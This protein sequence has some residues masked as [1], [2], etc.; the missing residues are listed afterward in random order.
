M[1]G[2]AG[3]VALEERGAAI[4]AAVE[5]GLVGLGGI[6]HRNLCDVRRAVAGGERLGD[7][8]FLNELALRSDAELVHVVAAEHVRAVAVLATGVRV[9]LRV[10]HQQHHVRLVLQ[11]DLG[12]ILETDVAH[13][14]VAADGPHLGQLAHFLVGHQRVVEA[15]EGK[16]LGLAGHVAFAREQR[17]GQSL[18]R[19]GTARVIDNRRLADE[20]TDG[21][22]VLKQRVHPRIRMRI[23]RRRGAVNGVAAG[24]RAHVHDAHAVG[25]AAVDGLHVAMIKR[26]LPHHS[27]EGVDDFLVGNGA[28]RVEP[29]GGVRV[30]LAAK[31]HHHVGHA[32]PIPVVLVLAA[33]F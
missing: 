29:G 30:V 4:L 21:R 13:R 7:A 3:G 33:R 9:H 26:V 27:A 28:V 15:G 31:P 16:I 6:G 23:G 10:E 20:P 32:A 2:L 19:H 18:G 17:I 14:T 1:L 12:N 25:V 22:A 8:L 24:V 5:H 11:N